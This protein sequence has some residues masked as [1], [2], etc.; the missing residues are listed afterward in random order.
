MTFF[1]IAIA[2]SSVVAIA[3]STLWTDRA[4]AAV[5][6]TLNGMQHEGRIDRIGS[7][8]ENPLNAV[9]KS[10]E[11]A[12]KLIVIIDD[13]L[14]RVFIS[15]LQVRTVGKS[16]ITGRQR[17]RIKQ[18]VASSGRSIGSV[19]PILRIEPFDEYGR[20]IFSMQGPKRPINVI[21]GITEI[22]PSYTKV[23]GL[24][25][26][27]YVWDMRIATSSIDRKTLSRILERQIDQSDADE[28]L[29][30]VRLYI[31]AERYRDAIEELN[32]VIRDFPD[33]TQL[34]DRLTELQQM[35]AGRMLREIEHR[36]DAGQHQRVDALLSRFPNEGIAAETLLRVRDMHGEYNQQKVQYDRAL[37]LIA[38]QVAGRPDPA[39]REALQ[40]IHREIKDELSIHSLNRMADYLRFA[41]DASM[42]NDQKLSL[43]ISGWL[44]GSGS[45][46]ENL[47]VSL[48]L[49]EVRNEVRKYLRAARKHERDQSLQRIQELEGGTP[50]YLAKLIASMRPPIETQIETDGVPGLYKLTAKGIEEQPEFTY[51]LQLPPEYSPD[52]RYPCV[53]TLN[54]AGST[55]LQQID[56]WAGTYSEKNLMRM[57]QAARHG[58]VVIAPHW[59]KPFQ[60]DYEYSS[61]EHAAALFCLRDACA[62]VSIDTDRVFLSGHSIGG[63]A[64]W[65]IG[66]SHPDLWAGVV[67]IVANGEK[68]VKHYKENARRLPMYFVGGEKDRGW[69]HQNGAEFD[70]Y[71]K[72][73]GFNTTV[74][75][76]QGRGHEHFQDEIQRIFEWMGLSAHRRDFYPRQWKVASMRPWDNF[77]WWLELNDFPQQSMVFPTQW[78]PERGTRAIQT[79]SQIL[80]NGRITVRTGAR[81]A[82][83]WLSPDLANFAR[84]PVVSIN[85]RELREEIKPSVAVL[86][87]DVRTRG[88]RQHPFWAKAEWRG[89]RANR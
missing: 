24:L 59:T 74:V 65:D 21:Q 26:S 54:G 78:P 77:F 57:G 52:R 5:V 11:I 22:T 87:E 63:D 45:A 13:D 8:N 18:Q 42:G 60:R 15:R 33:R 14:R 35:L 53:V 76:F 58:Y 50:A 70:D 4:R 19:G 49:V 7:L 48:S 36:R 44:L 55:P 62:R 32:L 41:D 31:Q 88:D 85:G 43:A 69:L 16:L 71:F 73:G 38:E 39:I 28:R 61:R 40:A 30:V 10:G 2:V 9:R 51:H 81:R 82:T 84:G 83:V 20:R 56:W 3:G 34:Q 64:A 37:A 75:Q 23:Q 47:A 17:I 12:T 46:I 86:L 89:R 6:T 66:L 1:R 79:E 29:T 25:A 80:E 27:A 67:P 68:Y 72:G